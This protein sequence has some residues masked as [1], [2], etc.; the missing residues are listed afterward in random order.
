[1]DSIQISR[2]KTYFHDQN[3]MELK[4]IYNF[5]NEVEIGIS[6]ELVRKRVEKL[7]QK[8]VL[9]KTAQASYELGVQLI[10]QPTIEPQ[11]LRIFKQLKTQFPLLHFCLWNTKQLN[12]F[13]LHQPGRFYTIIEIEKEAIDFVFNFLKGKYEQVYD[14]RDKQVL[15]KYASFAYNSI[16]IKPLI[17]ESPQITVKAMPTAKLEKMLVDIYCD[18]DIFNA[19]QDSEL[20]F[21]YRTAFEKYSIN[22]STM[23]RYAKRRGKKDL[24]NYI[25]NLSKLNIEE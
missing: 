4:D 9:K 19:H 8:G 16:L 17:S 10:Y 14:S 22:R 2:F 1:M 11:T 24:L 18:K 20:E 13:M 7:I 15:E 25:N 5:Y 12:E 6:K 23:T 3:E 21:I